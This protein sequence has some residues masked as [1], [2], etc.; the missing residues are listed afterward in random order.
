MRRRTIL[1]SAAA[2]SPLLAGC[3]G[4]TPTGDGD[5]EPRQ[6]TARTDENCELTDPAH[7]GLSGSL[8]STGS[9]AECIDEMG[10][11]LV[12]ENERESSV[13]VDLEATPTDGEHDPVT[14]S[15]DL[16]PGERALGDRALTAGVAYDV[17]VTDGTS[18]ETG[19]WPAGSC[20][21]R[22]VA[23]AD[24][25]AIGLVEPYRGPGDGQHDCYAGDSRRLRL[26]NGDD[27][28]SVAVVVRDECNRARVE[29]T[30]DLAAGD[31]RRVSDAF[32]AGEPVTVSV[33]GS[34]VDD[35]EE[36]FENPCWGLSARIDADGNVSIRETA[37]D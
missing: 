11:R 18:S 22:G 7:S 27:D 13:S 2:G 23:L 9:G 4:T 36:T 24:E 37:A 14:R 10:V 26:Y 25:I 34:G 8:V 33:S 21:R 28:R 6:S 12:V 29:E 1:Q 32:L 15:Y 20:Y 16:A 17:A 31:V 3:L 5:A 35:V 30:Y 19:R